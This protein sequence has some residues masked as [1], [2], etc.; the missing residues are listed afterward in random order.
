MMLLNPKSKTT[1]TTKRN[2]SCN[3]RRARQLTKNRMR[4]VMRSNLNLKV[5]YDFGSH[6]L[7]T[8]LS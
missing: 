2:Q 5:R 1:T 3:G 8:R 6:L 4:L 7:T